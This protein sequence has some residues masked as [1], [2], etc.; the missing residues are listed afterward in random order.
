MSGFLNKVD[1][2]ME[3]PQFVVASR[4]IGENLNAVKAHENVRA[5]GPN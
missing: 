4:R 1:P 5:K 3:L 2:T